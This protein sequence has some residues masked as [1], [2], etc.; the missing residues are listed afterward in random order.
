VIVHVRFTCAADENAQPIERLP[1]D[2][3]WKV[4]RA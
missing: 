1:A 4:T 3:G 2:A